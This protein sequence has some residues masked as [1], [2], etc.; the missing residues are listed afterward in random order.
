[1]SIRLCGVF[2]VEPR[3]QNKIKRVDDI[4]G[5]RSSAFLFLVRT[6]N[7]LSSTKTSKTHW[8]NM[9][10]IVI[11]MEI[12]NSIKWLICMLRLADERPNR[13]ST[14]MQCNSAHTE[15]RSSQLFFCMFAQALALALNWQLLRSRAHPVRQIFISHFNTLL[16]RRCEEIDFYQQ[17]QQW[18]ERANEWNF[19]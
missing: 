1:M 3:R 15:Q 11:G 14:K 16:F 7:R 6:E 12:V 2:W 8:S 19:D 10:V 9:C 5:R 13:D 18:R 4:L 17:N